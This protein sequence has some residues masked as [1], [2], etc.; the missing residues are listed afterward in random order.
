MG[1]DDA[2]H[3]DG[4]DGADCADGADGAPGAPCGEGQDGAHDARRKQ[5]N[6]RLQ[7]HHAVVDEGWDDARQ[8]PGAA[9]GADEQQNEDGFGGRANARRDGVANCVAVVC[10]VSVGCEI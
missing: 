8:Q 4:A 10:R 3:V 9:E 7:D 6:L 5:E 1:A 2:G